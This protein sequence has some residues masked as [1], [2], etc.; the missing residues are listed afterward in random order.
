VDLFYKKWD[1]RQVKIA[2]YH[3]E[4]NGITER[5]I[6]TIKQILEKLDGA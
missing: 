6:S 5:A 3:P 2:V 4:S 1:I